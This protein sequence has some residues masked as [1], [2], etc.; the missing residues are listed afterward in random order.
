MKKQAHFFSLKPCK[1]CAQYLNPHKKP[2]IN[3]S[4][5][6]FTCGCPSTHSVPPF[7][8]DLNRPRVI[9]VRCVIAFQDCFLDNIDIVQPEVMLWAGRKSVRKMYERS[10]IYWSKG[11]CGSNI[12]CSFLHHIHITST[13]WLSGTWIL[14][15]RCVHCQW[16][17]HRAGEQG[18][19][20][21]CSS[22]AATVY[23][24]PACRHYKPLRMISSQ[25]EPWLVEEWGSGRH[26]LNSALPCYLDSISI[27]IY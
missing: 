20:E 7:G 12:Q 23:I 22:S 3:R 27:G 26:S 24:H 6:V 19:L 16:C 4:P 1:V 10:R 13:L 11:H 2:G 18:F 14:W 9:W 17:C 21:N 25:M 8:R 15:G 5:E